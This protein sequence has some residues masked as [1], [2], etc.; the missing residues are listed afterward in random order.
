VLPLRDENPTRRPAVVTVVLILLNI[1]LFVLV[2]QRQPAVE[3]IP[4]DVRTDQGMDLEAVNVPGETAFD[5]EH[6]AIPCE[7]VRG[8]PLTKDELLATLAQGDTE[9]CNTSFGI[10]EEVFPEKRVWFS[11]VLSMFL[12]TG[13]LHLGGNL[14]FLWIFGNN[15]EDHL[16]R[17]RYVLF[18]LLG[19]FV[20][21]VAHVLAQPD[22]TVP[23]IGAS[24]AIAAVM[25]AYLVWFPNARIWS[26]FILFPVRVRAKWWLLAW[27]TLQFFTTEDASVAWL[28]HVGGFVFGVVM[29]LLVRMTS[30][31]RTVMWTPDHR[32][33]AW[34]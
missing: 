13:W 27:F 15:I 11:V 9:A 1:G 4:L 12:H 31:G 29:G 2:Q 7:V 8:E 21:T 26:L 19:G 17:A 32:D 34:S 22:S 16:G 20:A 18:Y 24:G 33:E 23:V 30:R 28:A 25:G 5:L 6:A 3:P 14:L 10:G